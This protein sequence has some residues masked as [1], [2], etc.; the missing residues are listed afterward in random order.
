MRWWKLKVFRL[1]CR[2]NRQHLQE[3]MSLRFTSKIVCFF[4]IQPAISCTQCAS[5]NSWWQIKLWYRKHL[6]NIES[7][8]TT[9]SKSPPV[10]MIH[11]CLWSFTD[12]P[13]MPYAPLR[14]SWQWSSMLCTYSNHQCQ[15]TMENA[16][17]K[18]QGNR[19]IISICYVL[20]LCA[21]NQQYSTIQLIT[22][23]KVKTYKTKKNQSNVTWRRQKYM[24]CWNAWFTCN[25]YY[26]RAD[27]LLEQDD[28]WMWRFLEMLMHDAAKGQHTVP[29]MTQIATALIAE[30]QERWIHW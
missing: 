25:G 24:E 23:K 12:L 8:L 22:I 10:H 20:L 28:W 16:T 30:L 3:S 2:M 29:W 6:C 17:H 13:N 19:H 1:D 4:L 14:W 11:C 7:L 15:L 27:Q 18:R 5:V 26:N 21:R 9:V